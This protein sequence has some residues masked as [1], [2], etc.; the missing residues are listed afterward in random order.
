MFFNL[1]SWL[2]LFYQIIN[3]FIGFLSF[4]LNLLHHIYEYKNN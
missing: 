3:F 2:H 1:Y 4:Y